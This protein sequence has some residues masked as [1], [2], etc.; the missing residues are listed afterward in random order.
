LHD[1]IEASVIAECACC[2]FGHYQNILTAK[3]NKLNTG[4][5]PQVS[6]WVF[7]THYR[8]YQKTAAHSYFRSIY[9]VSDWGPS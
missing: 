4:W 8:L 1:C 7:C 9:F 5:L 6:W 2:W 3:E